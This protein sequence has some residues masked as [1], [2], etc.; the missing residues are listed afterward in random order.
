MLFCQLEAPHAHWQHCALLRS[1]TTIRFSQTQKLAGPARLCAAPEY[2]MLLRRAGRQCSALAAALVWAR[3]AIPLQGNRRASSVRQDASSRIPDGSAQGYLSASF[4][5]LSL[6]C[7]SWQVQVQTSP[8]T[9]KHR[10]PV[11]ACVPR[12]TGAW[13]R[14]SH[15]VVTT[16]SAFLDLGKGKGVASACRERGGPR[17]ALDRCDSSQ[18]S[19]PQKGPWQFQLSLNP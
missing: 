10:P 17:V 18:N 8:A 16:V 11:T 7:S 3:S 1:S 6:V 12:A 15:A 19:G 2:V 13:R 9:V 14:R 5:R 4:V